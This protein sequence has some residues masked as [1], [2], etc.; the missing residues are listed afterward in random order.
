VTSVPAV[1]AGEGTLVNNGDGTFSYSPGS[2]F[3]ELAEGV[4]GVT[5][6]SYTA[7]DQHNVTSAVG[8][9]EITVTGVNDAPVAG[10]DTYVVNQDDVLDSAA[11]GTVNSLFHN[12]LDVDNGDT[13]SL[14]SLNG[15]SLTTITTPKGATLTVTATGEFVYDPTASVVLK[16]MIQNQWTEDVISYQVE[17]SHGEVSTG[18]VTIVV[19]G[20]NNEPEP[21]DDTYQVNQDA[22]LTTPLGNL[23]GVLANDTDPDQGDDFTLS[24]LQGQVFPGGSATITGGSVR[25]A[26]VT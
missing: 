26:T 14:K 13:L 6:F 8:T 9:G 15:S 10:N 12:D 7:K 5:Q 21:V 19:S 20:V 16:A 25:N 17:D 3:Q 24:R 4:T 23:A 2:G 1:P 11:S 18:I 22:V